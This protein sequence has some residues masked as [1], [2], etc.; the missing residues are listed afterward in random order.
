MTRPLLIMFVLSILAWGCSGEQPT[1]PSPTPAKPVATV[2]PTPAVETPGGDASPLAVETPDEDATPGEDA[3]PAHQG[4]PGADTGAVDLEPLDHVK[5]APTITTKRVVRM[6]T[7]AGDLLIE[8]YPEAAPNAAKR[9]IELTE[10]GF[11]DNTP[12]FRVVKTPRP[13]VAQFGVNWRDDYPKTWKNNLF[14]DDPSKYKLS[15][16]TLAFAKG[17]PNTNSTQ[18]FVNYDD[19][20]ALATNGGF[21]TF[22]RVVEGMDVA[23]SWKSLGDPAMGL[24]QASLWAEGDAYLLTLPEQP[25][26]IVKMEIVE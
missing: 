16:G 11:F 13:F 2:T 21:T 24:S 17:G 19:N 26:M 10:A 8:V 18:I 23:D 7:D 20:S 4:T 15:R 9:F 12:I 25:N 6:K 22:A 14:D 3:T 1:P 5:D